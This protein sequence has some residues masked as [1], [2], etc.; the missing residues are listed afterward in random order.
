MA[1][2]PRTQ[3]IIAV[4]LAVLM[5]G[6]AGY[7]FRNP[8]DFQLDFAWGA[9]GIHLTPAPAWVT[10]LGWLLTGLSIAVILLTLW[11]RHRKQH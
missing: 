11:W 8:Y 10:L 3:R 1:I 4:I 2:R 6:I 9:I 7:I 5:I